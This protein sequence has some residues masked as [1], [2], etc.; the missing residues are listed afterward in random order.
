MKLN[1]KNVNKFFRTGVKVD[2]GFPAAVRMLSLEIVDDN[3]K[4]VAMPIINREQWE[5]MTAKQARERITKLRD[6]ALSLRMKG[7]NQRPQ[8]VAITH[9]I[10]RRVR[11]D[12]NV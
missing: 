7:L 5:R 2:A 11:F 12:L 10:S 3:A 6:E 9:G 8:L 4:L 1:L